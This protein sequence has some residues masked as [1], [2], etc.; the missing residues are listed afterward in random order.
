MY[1]DLTAAFDSVHKFHYDFSNVYMCALW[2]NYRKTTCHQ[3]V[4]AYNNSYL[5][6][7]RLPMRCSASGMFATANVNY[8][9]CVIYANM[10][11]V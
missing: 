11:I 9:T 10:C 4:V 2:V 6:L 5:I 7:N 8:C 1:N 3:C